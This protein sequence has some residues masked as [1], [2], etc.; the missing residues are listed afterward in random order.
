M[1]LITRH[2]AAMRIAASC[3]FAREFELQMDV[4]RYGRV[5]NN[6]DYHVLC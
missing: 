5:V 3:G 6:A 4:L 1:E 2:F